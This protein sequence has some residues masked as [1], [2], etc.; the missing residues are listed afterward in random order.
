MKPQIVRSARSAMVSLC[1]AFSVSVSAQD[2]NRALNEVLGDE[3]TAAAAA[4]QPALRH[5]LPG[6]DLR[7]WVVHWN[8][9]AINA[10]A[11]DHTPVPQGE[12]RTAGEQVGPARTARALAIVQIAVFDALNA[13]QGGYRSY[14]GIPRGPSTAS[15]KIAIAQAA[16]DTLVQLYPS[17]AAAFD[18]RLAESVSRSTESTT[19]KEQGAAVGRTAAAAI[20]NARSADGS[21]H[22][23]PLVGVEYIP[24][25]SPG[26]WR[27]DPI[28]NQPVALG[29]RWD[30]VRPFVIQSASQ[31][32]AP[33]PPALFS[34]EYASAFRE[35]QR[36]G[37]DGITTPTQR[38]A[39][40]TQIGIYWGYDG[41][42]GIGVP[43]RLYN[44]IV[45]Q[46][47]LQRG[48]SATQ[49]A[50]LLA[51]VNV[52]LA[53]A[54]LACWES[55]Y[56]YEF[57]RPVTAIREGNRDGNLGTAGDPNF[58]PLGAPA[59]NVESGPNFTPPFP[60]YTSGHAT[61][62]GA[63]FQTLRRFYGT[64]NIQFT[65]VSD[66]FNGVTRDNLGNVRPRRSRTFSTLSAASDENAVS[67]IYL[68]IHWIFDAREGQTQG[69]RIADYVL[70]RTF[71]RI[72]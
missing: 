36:L 71:V 19:V 47:A 61:F 25:T 69:E 70:Q 48:T 68:G 26:D 1:L 43:P 45:V 40:Q 23:E 51:L 35:V 28:A 10:S 29:A 21:Q 8:E 50:R 7:S 63:V 22:L 67:R 53:D 34:S 37:G 39:T 20:L 62:G 72:N 5:P 2:P 57:W 65:F 14:T 52:A 55:K 60:V 6:A 11:L 15:R 13:I 24:G 46:I 56:F 17:Q 49:T 41:T 27:P 31:F 64:N 44:Q 38:S 4:V 58:V 3:V 66:E 42:P 32:R 59:S 9:L 18:A 54:A 33:P 30:E 12:S 16:H